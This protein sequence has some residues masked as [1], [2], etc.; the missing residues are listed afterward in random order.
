[1]KL[2]RSFTQKLGFLWLGWWAGLVVVIRLK[3]KISLRKK[4]FSDA[5]ILFRKISFVFSC[6]ISTNVRAK[7]ARF[8]GRTMWIRLKLED[9]SVVCPEIAVQAKATNPLKLPGFVPSYYRYLLSLCKISLS[10]LSTS[11]ISK[12]T[13]AVSPALSI[14][15]V[16]AGTRFSGE[17][18]LL[19]RV[20][21]RLSQ[22]PRKHSGCL[23][24]YR[25]QLPR[26]YKCFWHEFR[27]EK[28][29]LKE[30]LALRKDHDD[31]FLSVWCSILWWFLFDVNC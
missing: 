20:E 5:Y 13:M 18:K 19:G 30:S 10:F 15:G 16:G 21:T 9:W 29:S 28:L 24:F 1:M 3:N 31:S 7:R 25:H 14:A 12:P 2:W 22:K 11:L 26:Y 23:C 8:Y 17:F 6:V 27:T 4:V